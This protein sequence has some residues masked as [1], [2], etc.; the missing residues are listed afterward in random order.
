VYLV[1]V[2]LWLVVST[3]AIDCMERL[4]TCQVGCAP[5]LTRSLTRVLSDMLNV[6][7]S[8]T[9]S[10]FVR[11]HSYIEMRLSENFSSEDDRGYMWNF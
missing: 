7:H 10:V 4:V 2:A 8:F 6:A 1:S 5:L 9:S 11:I 3:S